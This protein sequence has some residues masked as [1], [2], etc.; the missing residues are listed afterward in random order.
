MKRQVGEDVEQPLESEVNKE[1]FY[2]EVNEEFFFDEEIHQDVIEP[3]NKSFKE[4]ISQD[5]GELSLEKK[6]GKN[7]RRTNRRREGRGRSRM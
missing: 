3:V 6:R 4:N 5:V 7:G 2:A 1:I